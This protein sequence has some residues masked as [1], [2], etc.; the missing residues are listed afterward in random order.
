MISKICLS[1]W[2]AEM[3]YGPRQ[4]KRI[5]E[6]T[7]LQVATLDPLDLEVESTVLQDVEILFSGWGGPPVDARLRSL[8]P[9]L[10]LYLYAGGT[11]RGILRESGPDSRVVVCSSVEQ[12]SFCVAEYTLAFILLGLKQ[13]LPLASRIR[14]ERGYPRLEEKRFLGNYRRRVGLIAM[15]CTAR[16]LVAL[17]RAHDHEIIVFDPYVDEAE[18]EALGVRL[19]GLEEL[20]RTSHVVSVHAPVT[21]E[22]ASMISGDHIRLMP[23][24]ATFINTSRGKILDEDSVVSALRERPDIFTVLDVAA[25]E[26]PPPDSA[27]YDL[28]N[29][30]LTPHIAGALFSECTRLGDA[31]IDEAQRFMRGE[32]LRYQVLPNRNRVGSGGGLG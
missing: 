3:V 13:A 19:V 25:M 29:V 2:C 23:L 21:R 18:A 11:P 14:R 12:N 16:Q 24:Q 30:L 31:M 27:L 5:A 7:S 20:F 22:T 6:L 10:K 15:G 26:P 8:A 1:S 32:P 17:L 9:N 4:R 28:E